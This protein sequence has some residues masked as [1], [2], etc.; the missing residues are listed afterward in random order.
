MT[1]QTKWALTALAVAVT[2]GSGQLSQAQI[3][4][5]G[6]GAGVYVRAPY[7]GGIRV[8]VGPVFP[9]VIGVPVRPLLPRRR[10]AV[11]PPVP[12]IPPTAPPRYAPGATTAMARAAA[13]TQAPAR[14]RQFPSAREL[15]ALDDGSL[16][17]ALVDAAT[18]LDADV[19]Q[20]NTG[21][22]WRDY[23]RLP[24][25][26]LPPPTQDGRVLLGFNSLKATLDKVNAIADDSA[27]PMI[28]GL[29]SFV[30]TQQA[31][32][33][34]INRYGRP[35]DDAADTGET[36]P[37]GEEL[38]TPPPSLS[39]PENAARESSAPGEHSILSR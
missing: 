12:A 25:D 17:N 3:V 30:A 23:F 27:Y 19:A 35:A 21:A 24:D 33:E 10:F 4:R 6:R 38:P 28:S 8:G 26:A 36:P 9:G 16:L 32:T 5:F 13:P 18:Q 34:V 11:V 1:R 15:A 14:F 7:V 20:F 29:A 37:Q 31:L 39:E 22:G 2:M